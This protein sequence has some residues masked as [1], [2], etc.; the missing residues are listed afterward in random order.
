MF[1]LCVALL[2]GAIMRCGLVT[3]KVSSGLLSLCHLRKHV[4]CWY[5]ILVICVHLR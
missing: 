5:E 2:Y 4:L 1:Y 3:G